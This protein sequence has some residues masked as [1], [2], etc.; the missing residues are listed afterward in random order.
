M[1][2]TKQPAIIP[3]IILTLCA[4]APAKI[5]Y[6]DD[7]GSPDGD[8]S[9]W[10]NAY[11]YLQDA[12][13][14]ANTA[15]K[16]VEVWVAQGLYTPDRTSTKPNGTRNRNAAF[17]IVD[18]VTLRGGY[19]GIGAVDSN[20][21]DVALYR[22]TLSGD[23]AGDD[24]ELAYPVGARDEPTRKDNCYHVVGVNIPSKHM[25]ASFVAEVDGFEITGGCALEWKMD[26]RL[27]TPPGNRGGGIYVVGLGESGESQLT[28]RDC[29]FTHNY[30]EEHG[31]AI[32]ARSTREL[33]LVRC[34]LAENGT[35][36]RGG[37]LYAYPS[38]MQVTA[39]RFERNQ[40]G[41]L[42]GAIVGDGG[43]VGLADC[44]LSD[45]VARGGG[46][47]ALLPSAILTCTECVLQGNLATEY[48]G[49]GIHL[50]YGGD[51]Q[52]DRC[53]F[54]GNWTAGSGGAIRNGAGRYL[55][56]ANCLLCGNTA[57]E[58]G[59]AIWSQQ[60]EMRIVN[61]TAYGNRAARGRFL[62]HDNRSTAR[63]SVDVVNCIV[64]DEG[65]EICVDHNPGVTAIRYTAMPGG[66]D[67][68]WD[69]AGLVA[70]GAGNINADPC[71][72]DTGHWSPNESLEDPNNDSFVEGDY[73][74]KSQAGRWDPNEQRWVM[75]DV[76]SPCID[77]GDPNTPVVEEPQPN[78]GQINMGAYG[79][80]SEASKSRV[81]KSFD[82]RLEE[83]KATL[84]GQSPWPLDIV[85]HQDYPS[86]R[87]Y[88]HRLAAPLGTHFAVDPDYRSTGD[89]AADWFLAQWRDLF[90]DASKAASFDKYRVTL[91]AGRTYVRYR[92]KYAG[93]EVFDVT[94]IIQVDENSGVKAVTSDILHDTSLLD[95]GAVSLT[96]SIDAVG[97]QDKATAFFSQQYPGRTFEA[98]VPTLMI[99]DPDVFSR[100]RPIRLVWMMDVCSVDGRSVAERVLVDAHD[101]EITLHYTLILN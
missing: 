37:G 1:D 3:L 81:A 38:N 17:Q 13:A 82:E 86:H 101:G 7:D 12:L 73:H 88:I 44:T 29:V 5:I 15:E 42:G 9:S 25:P 65:E 85:I 34:V 99:Y 35:Y 47:I 62:M 52:A 97:A 43:P 59:G 55:H 75:D 89:K 6:V 45:N 74:L 98:S 14:D 49:G 80:T 87:K 50:Y 60:G 72:V 20:S 16:P 48:G 11:K 79:G 95:T 61:C 27:Q 70:W 21:R 22:T 71:F 83:L 46:A 2:R 93:L 91:Y 64:S 31:G 54:I 18:K 19:A 67:V 26:W 33:T 58:S 92:Q 57:A 94:L 36:F 96:P 32:Y 8:G 68:V 51:V 39:S 4:A 23:L 53:H 24:M 41:E 84:E 56:I 30:A 69:P 66:R 40:A 78:G 90:V 77:A 10:Q 100:S 76:S 63:S 28:I